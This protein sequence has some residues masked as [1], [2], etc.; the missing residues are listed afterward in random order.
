MPA[1]YIARA[2]ADSRAHAHPAPG[3]SSA[4]EAAI[5]FAETWLPDSADRAVSIT[6]TDCET[7]HDQ[8]FRIDLDDG[9]AQPC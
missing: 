4:L 5:L 6:V 2:T 8:C 3:A 9:S 1:L 7:G